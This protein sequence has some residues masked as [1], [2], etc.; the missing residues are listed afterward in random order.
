MP[1]TKRQTNVMRSEIYR[2]VRNNEGLSTVD[3]YS[4]Y[5]KSGKEM[6]SP[7]FQQILRELIADEFIC[8][9]IQGKIFDQCRPRLQAKQ[10]WGG[11]K[12]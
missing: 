6:G 2:F 11:K 12:P 7:M 8:R 9:T 3:L 10:T 5:I 1:R 4:N